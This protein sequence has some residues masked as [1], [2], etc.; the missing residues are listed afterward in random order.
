MRC[1]IA[2]MM[3]LTVL[4]TQRAAW[5]ASREAVVAGD[6]LA[7]DSPCARLVTID[8]D[9]GL[10]GKVVISAVADHQEELDRLVF[11]TH[12]EAQIGTN[13][14]GCWRPADFSPTLEMRIRVPAKMKLSID[15]SGAA[16]YRIGAVG[17]ALTLDLSGAASLQA[18]QATGL[19]VDL[20]GAGTVAVGH[21]EGEA[22]LDLSGHGRITIADAN[23]ANVTLDLSGAGQVVVAHGQIGNAALDTSGFG[24]VE[25][26]A[27][28]GSATVDISGAGTVHFAKVTGALSKDVSGIGAVR[29]G[30]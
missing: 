19:T 26:G 13:D 24:S 5:A 27:V 11:E 28:V 23:L 29:V 15:E 8:P 4:L 1:K 18:E 3:L 14:Q 20:S 10:S 6:A 7:I 2:V 17:G 16:R 30:D 21:A 22:H 12:G 25:I 9:P